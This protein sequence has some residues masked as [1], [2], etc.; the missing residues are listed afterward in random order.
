MLSRQ[1]FAIVI[2]LFLI[3]SMITS[4]GATQGG[5][6]VTETYTVQPGDTLWAIS[7]Q[8]IQ[9]NTYGPRDIREFYYGVIE[10]NYDTV[11][12]DRLPGE[13]YPGDKLIINYWVK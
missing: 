8:Y 1:Y 10:L 6:M 5:Q 2:L 9:K 13:I 11:F 12:K 3:L 4:C 7:E